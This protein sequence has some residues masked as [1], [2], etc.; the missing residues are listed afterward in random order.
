MCIYVCVWVCFDKYISVATWSPKQKFLAPPLFIG[1]Y[2]IDW[3]Y[4]HAMGATNPDE[5]GPKLEDFLGCCYSNSP[6]DE[7]KVY[8]QTQ[9]NQNHSN[10]NIS[11]IN[12][13]IAPNNFNTNGEIISGD[14]N[15]TTS[16]PLFQPYNQFNETTQALMTSSG[17]YKSWLGQT[18]FSDAI[19]TN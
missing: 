12:V 17:M 9:E 5:D 2:F 1:D 3:R 4:E 7:T 18:P 13:N 6:P 11:K 16:S 10:N 8:C 14:N 15:L 19:M